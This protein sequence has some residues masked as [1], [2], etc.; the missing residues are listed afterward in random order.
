MNLYCRAGSY[1]SRLRALFWIATSSFVFPVILN[2]IQL[3]FAYRDPN[4]LHCE[5][6]YWVNVY[7]TIVGALLATIWCSSDRA[8][9]KGGLGAG[10]EGVR[11]V[12]MTTVTLSMPRFNRTSETATTE[13]VDSGIRETSDMDAGGSMTF[14]K[15]QDIGT[16]EAS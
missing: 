6:I 13:T 2:I 1:I 10:M 12:G 9:N 14:R 16:Y 4:F 8:S 7:V 5:Y 15:G 11:R 3:A